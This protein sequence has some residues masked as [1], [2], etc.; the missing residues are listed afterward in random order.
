MG[1]AILENPLCLPESCLLSHDSVLHDVWRDAYLCAT[2]TNPTSNRV[3][4]A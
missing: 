1:V 4:G 3:D 2:C